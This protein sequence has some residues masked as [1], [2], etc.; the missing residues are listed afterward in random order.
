MDRIQISNSYVSS[1]A[2]KLVETT[3]VFSP[4]SLASHSF[5]DMELFMPYVKTEDILIDRLCVDRET[6]SADMG[7]IV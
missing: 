6:F 3:S 7:T 2:I 5:V 4:V 1:V